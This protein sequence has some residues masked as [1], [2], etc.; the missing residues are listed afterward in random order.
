MLKSDSPVRPMRPVLRKKRGGGRYEF[1]PLVKKT[2]GRSAL[3]PETACNI[4]DAPLRSHDL[5]RCSASSRAQGYDGTMRVEFE[6][7]FQNE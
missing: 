3:K 6:R 1:S 4:R 5:Q 2:R 7:S